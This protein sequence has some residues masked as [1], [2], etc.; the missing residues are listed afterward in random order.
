VGDPDG[1]LT[2]YLAE[3]DAFHAGRKPRPEMEG[4]TVKDACNAFLNAR[5]W[6]VSS[7]RG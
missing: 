6:S 5:D 3:K 4:V 2:M 1:A 7:I